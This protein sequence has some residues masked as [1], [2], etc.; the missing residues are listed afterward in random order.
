MKKK[1]SILILFSIILSLLI[2]ELLLR[3]IGFKPW[4]YEKTE[5]KNQVIFKFDPN[6]GWVSKKGIY[7]LTINDKKKTKIKLK[8][9]ENGNRHIGNE[10]LQ[11]N[12]IIFIGGSFTQGWGVNDNE[13]FSY[14]IQK[15]FPDFSIYNFGQSGYGGL[16]S[17]MLLKKEI[18]N[19]KSSKLIIYGFINHHEQRNVAR[20]RWLEILLKYSKR[21]YKE[22]PKIP[23]ATLNKK[24][25]LIYHKPV[26]YI[27]LPLRDKLAF[28]TLL[29][30]FYM[31]QTT[32]YRKNIQKNVTKK[33]FIEMNKISK[34]NQSNFLVVNLNSSNDYEKILIDNNIKFVDCGLEL[35]ADLSVP[36]DF[37][38]NVKAHSL[39]GACISEYIKKN[40]LLF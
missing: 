15:K 11:K 1:E 13:T 6:I 12:K 20:S 17:L 25:E 31:K 16:Q 36:N 4:N 9:Q 39:Y 23:Y 27:R 24:D 38:P 30:K 34:K 5:T 14:S 37:H 21:G 3:I 22:I 10:D 40:K 29:E 28:I 26:S 7:E 19:L 2:I 32:K 33:I 35:T 18:K 8:I